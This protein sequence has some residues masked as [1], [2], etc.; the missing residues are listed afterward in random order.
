MKVYYIFKIKEEFIDLY[1]DSPSTLFHILKSIY[2]LDQ[3]EVDYGYNLFKQLTV[4]F[5]K[6]K[7]D[8]SLS[9]LFLS[10]GTVNCSNRSRLWL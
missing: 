9:N 1:K 4:P 5:D 8:R 6:N 3:T 10:K 7:L 2:Y